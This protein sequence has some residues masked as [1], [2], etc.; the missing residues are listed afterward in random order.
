MK[1]DATMVM[2]P[3]EKLLAFGPQALSDVELLALFLRTGRPGV[4]VLRFARQMLD[5]FGSL[6]ALLSADLA[7]FE[8]IDGVGVATF[9]QLNTVGEMSRRYYAAQIKETCLLTSPETT[10]EFLCA[11]LAGEQREIFIVIFLDNQHRVITWSRMFSGTLAHVEVH[12]R[13]IIREAL[14]HNAAAVILAH[15]HP[16]GKAE[17]S[18]AD[19]FITRQIVHTCQ[20]LDIRVLD[21]LVIGHGEC[22]SF[23]ERGWI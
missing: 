22:V 13:E 2:L 4:H 11:E 12:P 9:A 23:A 16:S 18:K 5:H 21:H 14:R 8:H 1:Y 10:R 17:P 15:N 3:R 19:H 7:A 20:S 6:R